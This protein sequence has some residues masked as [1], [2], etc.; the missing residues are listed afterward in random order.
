MAQRLAELLHLLRRDW[1]LPGIQSALAQAAEIAPALDVCR[2]AIAC[3]A[4]EHARTPGLIARPGQHWEKTTAAALTRPKECPDHPGQHA[5][6][7]AACAAEVASVPPPGWRDGIPKAA[8]HDHTNPIDDAGL[9]PE[10][11]AAAR[12]R[13]D[14]EET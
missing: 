13:A 6:R 5:L 4:N 8:K 2:A 1:D 14:E 3:A 10:A 11:Y 7:C 9:D 12:A